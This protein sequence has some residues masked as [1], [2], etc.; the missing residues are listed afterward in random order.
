MPVQVINLNRCSSQVRPRRPPMRLRDP[1]IGEPNITH[2]GMS[3][4]RVSPTWRL[5]GLSA[6]DSVRPY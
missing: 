6:A 1:E 4:H 3:G 5:G 2:S